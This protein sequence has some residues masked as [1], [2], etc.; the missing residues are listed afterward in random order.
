MTLSALLKSLVPRSLKTL[1]RKRRE[2]RE[3]TAWENAGRPAP[4][5]HIVKQRTITRYRERFGYGVLVETGTYLGDMVE[6]QRANFDR[7][8]SVELSEE[9]YRKAAR[10]FSRNAHVTIIQGDSSHAIPSL[11]QEL[12][13]PAIFWLDGH[14][15]GGETAM[16]D[17]I[18][19][20]LTEIQAILH[21][22]GAGHV[23]LIDDA[24]LFVEGTGYPTVAEVTKQV[25]YLAPHYR[26]NV[27]DDCL[28]FFPAWPGGFGPLA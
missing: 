24:R 3:L 2:R 4:P 15:S 26:F 11:V 6:A 8:Y 18:S 25:E 13:R 19:P 21:R 20:V 10:R 12:N 7:I 5:P 23:L 16:G 1:R 22:P 27:S 14:Y 17:K 9:L 28:Q